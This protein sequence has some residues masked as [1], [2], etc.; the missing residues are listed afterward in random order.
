MAPGLFAFSTTRKTQDPS[1]QP[2]Q[3]DSARTFLARQLCPRWGAKDGAPEKARN[4][5]LKPGAT[6]TKAA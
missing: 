1:L 2:A 5:G 6:K 3:N 4:A